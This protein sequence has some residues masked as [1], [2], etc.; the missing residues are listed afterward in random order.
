MFNVE[1]MSK[2]TLSWPDTN[3]DGTLFTGEFGL[4]TTMDKTQNPY[5]YKAFMM[6]NEKV[7]GQ[8]YITDYSDRM[9]QRDSEKY[10]KCSQIVFGNHGQLFDHRDPKLVEKFLS[11]YYD[12]KVKLCW[13]EEHCNISNGYPLWLFGCQDL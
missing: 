12:K 3:T 8:I 11:L 2:K 4:R 13:I 7:K 6:W 9:Y 5:S 1:I 10:N